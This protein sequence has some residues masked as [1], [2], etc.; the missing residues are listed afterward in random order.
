MASLLRSPRKEVDVDFLV[1]VERNATDLLTLDILTF[2]GHNPDFEGT[3]EQVARHLGRSS[4]SS[5]RAELGDL[6]LKGVLTKS[7]Q[8]GETVAYRLASEDQ[9]KRMV[10]KLAGSQS[11]F[12]GT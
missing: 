2:F 9:V 10:V 3:V 6:A 12:P 7:G 11:F 1:F 8:M 4:Q 5:I